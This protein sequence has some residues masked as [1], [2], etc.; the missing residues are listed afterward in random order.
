[1]SN[2]RPSLT[3]I[4]KQSSDVSSS[5]QSNSSYSG[6]IVRSETESVDSSNK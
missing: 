3:S 5:S 1:M 4:I 2:A 6:S